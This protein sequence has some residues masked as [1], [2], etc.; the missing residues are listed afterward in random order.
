[1]PSLPSWKLSTGT[2][3]STLRYPGKKE[4]VQEEG[5]SGRK[6]GHLKEGDKRPADKTGNPA[7]WAKAGKKEASV[8]KKRTPR[9]GKIPVGR[10]EGL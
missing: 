8:G 10:S 3:R 9:K 5:L 4:G 2:S 1:M 7:Q 6:D